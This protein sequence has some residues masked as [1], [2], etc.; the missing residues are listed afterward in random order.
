M[1]ETK[2]N[3]QRLLQLRNEIKMSEALINE[4]LKP[5]VQES[6]ARYTNRYI[7]AIGTDWDVIVNEIYPVIQFYLPSIFFRNPRVF[8]KPRNKT[9][10]A[11]KRDPISGKMVDVQMDSMKSAN[12]QEAILNYTLD[13]IKY[14]QE[15][16]RVLLDSLLF[17]H[18][19]L[20]HGY[21]GDFG[22][23]E[24]QSLTIK[25]EQ[26]FAKRISPLR[27]LKDPS[28]TMSDIPEAKWVARSFDVPLQDLIEDDKLK[29]DKNLKGFKGFGD[30]VEMKTEGL[31]RQT[32]VKKPLL[33][34]TEEEYKKSIGCDFVK[35]YEVFLRP[36]KKEKREGKSGKII[37]LA[38]GQNKPLRVNDWTIK[39]EGFPVQV[40]QFNPVPDQMFALPDT[41][42]YK[43]IADQKNAIFNIQLRNAQENSKVWVGLS[44]ESANEEDVDMVRNGDQTIVRFEEGNPRDRM[45]ITSA[46]GAASNEL[47]LVDQ[48]IQRNLDEKSGVS[49]LKK[50]FLQ[51]GEESAT[52]V[53]IRNAG[54]SAR[55]LYRQDIMA[56]FLKESIHYLNQLLKQFM[57]VKDAV[58]IMGTLDINW[59]ENPAK[60]D[61]QADTDVTI[62]VI[63]MLPENPERELSELNQVLALMIQAIQDPNVMAKL[64]QE[65]KTINIGPI[66]EQILLR[67]KIR[68]PEIFRN[69][70]PEESMGTVQVQQLKEAQANVEAAV[71]GQPIPFPPKQEDDHRAK[72][73]TYSA[74][75]RLFQQ[76][77]QQ[78]E[79][80]NQLIIIHQQILQQLQEKEAKA[81]QRVTLKKPKTEKI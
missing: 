46:G 65:N 64:Q 53:R 79:A 21:K 27:F 2:L 54:S 14:K 22:Y 44:K 38:E 73:E 1:T 37:L 33:D 15:V 7:P 43:D 29:I 56:E 52:S 62:D 50:G 9:Y 3:D 81:G 69:I 18:G 78:S 32:P 60:E 71:T 74:I 17:P 26:V 75:A 58:R 68:N 23:T 80:L 24:E 10:I 19:I 16:Q 66:V 6:I 48:R 49:E 5:F 47:F 11:K 8:L 39:A 42:V 4:S 41:A 25:K 67:L 28:V 55:V 76:M 30:E 61:I 40:L 70:R 77:G 63:S 57:P 72:L 45:Y 35:V 51:S 20:W 34:F 36:T 31:D 13:E 59:I 12:T